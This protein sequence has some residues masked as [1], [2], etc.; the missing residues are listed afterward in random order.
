MRSTN[1]VMISML[2]RC[3]PQQH[4]A[5]QAFVHD[6][7]RRQRS[8]HTLCWRRLTALGLD[9]RADEGQRS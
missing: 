8:L 1:K 6:S 3:R 7:G 2:M 4:E 9:P 5:G